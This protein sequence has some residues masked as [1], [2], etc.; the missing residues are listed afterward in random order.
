M[1][2]RAISAVPKPVLALLALAL[3]LQIFWSLRAPPPQANA[4]ALPSPP[5]R[6]VIAAVSFGERIPASQALALYLQAFDNQPGI[7]I[8]FQHLDYSVVIQWLERMLELD[9]HAQYPLLMATHLYAQVPDPVRQKQMLDFTY[10][11]FFAAPNQRWQWLAHAAIVAKHR[12]HDLPLALKYAQ[13]ITRH[14]NGP[15]VPHWAQQMPIFILEEMGETESAKILL[16][17]LLA[18]NTLSDPHEIRF[19]T[20]RLNALET[21]SVEKSSPLSKSRQH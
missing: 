6:D 4:H 9:G 19:L 11:H 5:S 18:N 3:A 14:A 15:D 13:A 21:Q 8:P 20:E 2:E 17:G 12:L 10:Q 1:A 16:G 7:S